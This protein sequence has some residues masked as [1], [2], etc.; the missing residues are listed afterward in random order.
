MSVPFAMKHIQ[1]PNYRK[2]IEL[3]LI[4]RVLAV[5]KQPFLLE[6]LKCMI[7]L[8]RENLVASPAKLE[9]IIFSPLQLSIELNFH[10]LY[11][12]GLMI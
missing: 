8:L 4:G 12:Y 6:G 10:I 1:Q 3:Q 9:A 7:Y 5:P 11:L 2:E